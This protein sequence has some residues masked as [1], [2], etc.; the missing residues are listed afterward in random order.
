MYSYID[1]GKLYLSF[2]LRHF[3]KKLQSRKARVDFSVFKRF[4]RLSIR[5]KTSLSLKSRHPIHSFGT[6]AAYSLFF[7][8]LAFN[9]TDSLFKKKIKGID[10]VL[11]GVSKG[12]R[13]NHVAIN[14]LFLR[15]YPVGKGGNAFGFSKPLTSMLF[16]GTKKRKSVRY[17]RMR[18]KGVA[19]LFMYSLFGSY[20]HSYNTV[21]KSESYKTKKNSAIK[22]HKTSKVVY[23]INQ[24]VLNTF[25][26][27]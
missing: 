24:F 15:Y 2:I 27:P 23:A 17:L 7:L 6:F 18:N 11:S 12:K 5:G 1:N 4:K 22:V 3:V 26:R 10:S 14:R 20:P 13:Q 9:N 21:F 8:T 16:P 19:K 25:L